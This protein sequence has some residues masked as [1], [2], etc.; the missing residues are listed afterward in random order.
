MTVLH[1]SLT[2]ITDLDRV[3]FRCEPVPR[4]QWELGDYVIGRVNIQRGGFSTVELTTGRV[5]DAVEQDLSLI[6]I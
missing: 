3:E 1:T 4:E 5:I 6:H 2:R